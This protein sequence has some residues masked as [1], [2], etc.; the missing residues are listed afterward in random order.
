MMAVSSSPSLLPTCYISPSIEIRQSTTKGY[1]VLATTSIKVGTLLLRE[2]GIPS[3]CWPL[4]ST[5]T[6]APTTVTNTT[7][8]AS[9]SGSGSAIPASALV[10][11]T[12]T[13]ASRAELQTLSYPRPLIARRSPL[14]SISNQQ[15]SIAAA[16]LHA[17]SFTFR[18]AIISPS[19]ATATSGSGGSGGNGVMEQGLILFPQLARV[20]H[21]CWPNAAHCQRDASPLIVQLYAITDINAGM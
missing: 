7:A 16:Q 14:P 2:Q 6:T 20:N 15:W 17:N 4:N 18:R 21:S 11:L 19:T 13:I 10:S 12:E 3:S 5:T 9:G 1:H 8:T